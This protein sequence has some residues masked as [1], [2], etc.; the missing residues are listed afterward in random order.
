MRLKTRFSK[1]IMHLY[2]LLG[3]VLHVTTLKVKINHSN[4]MQLLTL[5]L[6]VWATLCIKHNYND[7]VISKKLYI[8]TRA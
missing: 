7:I 8:Y 3:H 4:L 6:K 1:H 5:H 2:C